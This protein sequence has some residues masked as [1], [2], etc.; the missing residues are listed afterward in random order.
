[1]TKSTTR[2]WTYAQKRTLCKCLREGRSAVETANE[3]GRTTSAVWAMKHKIKKEG[4]LPIVDG[5]FR[6]HRSPMPKKRSVGRP[7]K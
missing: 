6:N 2:A 1:M 7:R 4:I 3:L 5:A